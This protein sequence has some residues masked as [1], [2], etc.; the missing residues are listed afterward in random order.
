M[1][2]KI[3]LELVG[4]RKELQAILGCLES[5]NMTSVESTSLEIQ[6]RLREAVSIRN[7]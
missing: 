6:E 5:S 3:Y 2:K 1:L 7:N 4:I